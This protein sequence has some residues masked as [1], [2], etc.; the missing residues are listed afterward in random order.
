MPILLVETNKDL[1]Q[2]AAISA[3]K[4]FSTQAAELLGKPEAFVQAM[5]SPG[6]ALVMGGTADP[7]V[8]AVLQSIGLAESECSRLSEGLCKA[9]ESVLG[10][11]PARTYI[12]FEDLV[13]GRVGWDS[14]T[15]AG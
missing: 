14:K 1:D 4:E 7:A 12:L 10:V 3:A 9:F 13:R 15:F 2:D 6:K 8:Y 11:P 5:V